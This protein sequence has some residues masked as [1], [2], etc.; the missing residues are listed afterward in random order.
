MK[1]VLQEF[2]L[3]S[4]SF[5]L[6]TIVS[7]HGKGNTPTTDTLEDF[8]LKHG[9]VVLCG[10]PDKQF[11]SVD[12]K[13]SCSEKVKKEFDLAVALLHSFEYDEAEKAFAKIIDEEPECA[14]AYWGVAMCNYHPLWAPPNELEL[15]K[16]SKA[17]VLGRSLRLESDRESG[18]IDAIAEYY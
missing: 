10:P 7:C 9:E 11:G 6:L 2:S 1:K 13:T 4:L 3:V 15:K 14:M 18:Y 5:S 17:V 16:G 12:F 8:N